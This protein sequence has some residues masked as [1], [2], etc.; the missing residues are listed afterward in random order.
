MFKGRLFLAPPMLTLFF[1]RKFINTVEIGP[2]NGSYFGKGDVN[3]N[4]WFCD[5]EKAHHC[6]EL[7]LLMYFASL[8]VVGGVLAVGWIKN[9]PEKNE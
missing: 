2:Q 8:S 1:G 9:C 4:L 6:S 3:V 5:S 7:R